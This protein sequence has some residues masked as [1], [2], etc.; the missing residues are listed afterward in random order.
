MAYDGEVRLAA[1]AFAGCGFAPTVSGATIVDAPAADDDAAPTIDVPTALCPASYV[2]TIAASPTRYRVIT[3]GADFNTHHASCN[4]D[5]PGA[6]HLASF[7]TS[8]EAMA[9]QTVLQGV[10]PPAPADQYYIGAVQEPDQATTDAAWFVFTGAPLP[11]GLWAPTQPNDDNPGENNEEN[12]GAINAVDL[13]HDTT[14]DILYGAV[15]ECD[16]QAIDPT[17]QSYIP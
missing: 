8:A 6:T 13:L 4:A 16:G 5:A 12:L 3:T 10:T 14:G 15:C 1:L 7:E 9:I 2:V 11:A 17:V